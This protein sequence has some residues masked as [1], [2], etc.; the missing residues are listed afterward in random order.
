MRTCGMKS[1]EIENPQGNPQGNPWKSIKLNEISGKS[2][3]RVR[4][5]AT[6]REGEER[7]GIV[8][9]HAQQPLAFTRF[10]LLFPLQTSRVLREL[11][12]THSSYM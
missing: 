4:G 12:K 1:M 6:R 2:I 3:I 9:F 11:L 5:A 7:E 8:S 10:V